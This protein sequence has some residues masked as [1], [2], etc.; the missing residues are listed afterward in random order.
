MRKPLAVLILAGFLGTVGAAD[1][2]QGEASN[3]SCV[4]YFYSPTCPHCAE[5][6][7]HLSTLENVEAEKHVAAENSALLKQYLK[8]YDV[9][10]KYWG[11]VPIIFSDD[12]YAMG[13]RNAINLLN[14]LEASNQSLEC[15]QPVPTEETGGGESSGDSEGE[16]LTALSL[17]GL[18]LS[19]A[20]N[21][22]A[23]AVLVILLTSILSQYPD[24]RVKALKSGLAFSAAIAVTYFSMGVLLVFGFKSVS[25][26]GAEW[27][28]T[29]VGGLAILMGLLNLKDFISHGSFGFK[30]EVPV[31]WRPKMKKYIREAA[32]PLGAAAAGVVVSLFLL[33]CTSGPYFVAG[34]LLSGMDWYAALLLLAAY[35]VI[36][37]LPMVAATGLVYSGYASVDRVSSW[38]DDNIERLH[39]VAGT[40]LIAV[41]L[42]MVLGW[43]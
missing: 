6:E 34:G 35:N 31:S 2:V 25:S 11:S 13:S 20:V 3:Q 1:P 23:I 43:I 36:F 27:L 7:D 29:A 39:L 32:S 15:P 24:K 42:A 18:A 22:C 12:E 8:A 38:R 5:V 37:V 4:T 19:D 14:R 30:F 26:M 10:Q 28:F 33:P 17:A 16:K 21:P 9:P 41:G 40:V